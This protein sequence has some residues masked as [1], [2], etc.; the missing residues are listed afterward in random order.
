MS[1]RG[2]VP[3][4]E[5]IAMTTLFVCDGGEYREAS[6][7]LVLSCAEASVSRR[8]RTG[9]PVF[10]APAAIHAFLRLHL[11]C[12]PYEVFGCL[13]LDNRR[14]LLAREDLFRGTL[15][16]A[17]VYP[18]EVLRGCL[19]HGASKLVL[20]HNHPNGVCEPSDA[21]KVA[22]QRIQ[23]LAELI[24]VRVLDHWIVGDSLYSFAEHGLI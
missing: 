8:L 10:D 6:T 14:R 20:Y 5:D 2:A 12:L 15:D 21:D 7:D 13:Y 16:R 4:N 19:K 11:S 22:T 23:H 17:Q 9:S 1:S 3:L 24:D 18:R